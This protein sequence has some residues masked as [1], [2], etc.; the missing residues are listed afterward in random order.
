MNEELNHGYSNPDTSFEREDLSTRGVFVF[1]IGLAVVG[2]VIYF[3]IVGMYKFLDHYE[4][5]RM[6]ASSPLVATPRANARD[7][8]YAPDKDDSVDRAFKDNGAPMLEHDERSQFKD[9]LLKQEDQLNSYGWIDQQAGIAHIP[10]EQA[11]HLIVERGLPVRSVGGAEANATA[12]AAAA[13]RKAA[14]KD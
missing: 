7:I 4:E 10:I 8:P 2:L 5:S 1:M 12:T 14:P 11:M 9:F 3:I 13:T 6:S